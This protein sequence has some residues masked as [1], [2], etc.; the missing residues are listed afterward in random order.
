MGDEVKRP[1]T[2]ATISGLV[3]A[4]SLAASGP[5]TSQVDPGRALGSDVFVTRD[6][7]G[8]AATRARAT[9][10]AAYANPWSY[11][12]IAVQSVRYGQGDFRVHV[13][14]VLG[15]YRDQRR[16]TLAGIDIEAG[17]ARVAGHLRPVGE[18]TFRWHPAAATAVDLAVSADLVETQAALRRGIG[19]TF[20]SAAVEHEL[21]ERLTVAGLAGWQ[22]FSDGNA[23]T[24][25]R[26]RAIW[27]AVPEHGVSLQLRMRQ[28]ASRDDDVGGAYFNPDDHRQWLGVAAIRKRHA[29]WTFSAALGAGQERSSGLGWRPAYLAEVRAEGA[30]A[31]NVRLV[32][33]AGYNRSAGFVDDPDYAHRFVGLGIVIPFR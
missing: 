31:G 16:D 1:R 18:A 20:A 28:Y 14:A 4:A 17:V 6:S 22:S 33:R 21:G 5:A 32:V 2:L 23:R 8:M 27:L 12:G 19:Y 10:L 24:H 29:G 3:A 11:S 9:G 30:V 26:G 25:L 13:P 7:D 15:V